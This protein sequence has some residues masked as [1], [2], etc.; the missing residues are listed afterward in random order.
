[1]ILIRETL[2]PFS[3]T[4]P[5]D[6]SRSATKRRLASTRRW[7]PSI[8]SIAVVQC[9]P[10]ADYAVDQNDTLI[11]CYREKPLMD[12]RDVSSSDAVRRSL[13]TFDQI[14]REAFLLRYGFGHAREWDVASDDY[15]YDAKAV[16]GVAHYYQFPDPSL[17]HPNGFKSGQ[18][19]VN[20]K[21]TELGFR[22]ARNDRSRRRS[23]RNRPRRPARSASPTRPAA[24]VISTRSTSV[25]RMD[26]SRVG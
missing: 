6:R 2:L 7:P 26:G 23:A 11:P 22:L 19:T 13:A 17:R 25:I 14:G 18:A 1:M 8:A 20:R 3:R 12:I 4:G 10:P 9:N 21:L 5:S 16:L 24:P 15:H